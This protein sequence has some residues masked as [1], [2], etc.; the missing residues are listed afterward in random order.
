[1][2]RLSDHPEGTHTLPSK[3]AHSLRDGLGADTRAQASVCFLTVS[4]LLMLRDFTGG[5]LWVP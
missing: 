2:A 3:M 5:E 4:C 1:M